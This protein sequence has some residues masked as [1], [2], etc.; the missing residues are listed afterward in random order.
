MPS[1]SSRNGCV[2]MPRVSG[3]WLTLNSTK[4][5]R[6]GRHQLQAVA[7]QQVRQPGMRHEVDAGLLRELGHAPGDGD[8]PAAR[9]VRLHH[10][11]AALA[12]EALELPVRRHLLARRDRH[13]RVGAHPGVLL[14]VLGMDEVLDPADAVRGEPLAHRQRLAPRARLAPALPSRGIPAGVDEHLRERAEAED[15]HALPRDH[16]DGRGRERLDIGPA[17]QP[18]VGRDA[19]DELPVAVVARLRG[20]GGGAIALLATQQDGLDRD[21]PHRGAATIMRSEARRTASRVS[22]SA[23]SGA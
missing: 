3:L 14:E 18:L 5:A 6:Q 17:H 15:R 12:D 21:D 1:A 11:D 16:G 13:G 23:A 20:A 4:R 22:A 8:A 19:H 9:Q 7:G 2:V 10:V